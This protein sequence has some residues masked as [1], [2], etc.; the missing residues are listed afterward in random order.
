[1]PDQ[2]PCFHSQDAPALKIDLPLLAIAFAANNQP[3]L[4]FVTAYHLK[5][6]CGKVDRGLGSAG[7]TL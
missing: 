5:T 1:M 7:H 4:V 2:A 6:T 3:P